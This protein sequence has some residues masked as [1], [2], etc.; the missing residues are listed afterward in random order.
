MSFV[1]ACRTIA[2]ETTNKLTDKEETA[3]QSVSAMVSEKVFVYFLD[4]LLN[5]FS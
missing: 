5:F 1:K 3:C 2:T 4:L